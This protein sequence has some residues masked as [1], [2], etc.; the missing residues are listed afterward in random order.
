MPPKNCC[1][2]KSSRRRSS[3]QVLAPAPTTATAGGDG[4]G[5]AASGDASIHT[6]PPAQLPTADS[7]AQKT[8]LGKTIRSPLATSP[9]ATVS[10]GMLLTPAAAAPARSLGSTS[11]TPLMFDRA[12][13]PTSELK[14]PSLAAAPPTRTGSSGQNARARRKWREQQKTPPTRIDVG[15]AEPTP[16]AAVGG[17]ALD[18]GPA[19]DLDLDDDSDDSGRAWPCTRSVAT[20]AASPPGPRLVPSR[21]MRVASLRSDLCRQLCFGTLRRG[22]RRSE[23]LPRPHG[24]PAAVTAAVSGPRSLCFSAARGCLTVPPRTQEGGWLNDHPHTKHM[25]CFWFPST[26]T[27]RRPQSRWRASQKRR[28]ARTGPSS[29]RVGPVPR[30]FSAHLRHSLRNPA[31]ATV[32]HIISTEIHLFLSPISLI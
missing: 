31:H 30:V 21:Q 17:P 9:V 22:L 28:S 12:G 25:F 18:D 16:I 29:S 2:R 7:P 10:A 6:R 27:R 4:P 15:L 26:G 8:T 1:C 24:H 5:G 13:A 11:K 14:T 19:L 32:A 20:G 3:R 23:R